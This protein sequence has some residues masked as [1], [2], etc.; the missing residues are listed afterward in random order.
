[1]SGAPIL[2]DPAVWIDSR[3]RGGGEVAPRSPLADNK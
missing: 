3:T 1:M 2:A